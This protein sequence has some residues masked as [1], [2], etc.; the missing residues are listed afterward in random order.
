MSIT[1]VRYEMYWASERSVITGNRG[2]INHIYTNACGVYTHRQNYNLWGGKQF[3]G[4]VS[5]SRKG[6]PAAYI[7]RIGT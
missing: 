7:F 6:K 1:Y 3:G 5:V 2:N 4:S